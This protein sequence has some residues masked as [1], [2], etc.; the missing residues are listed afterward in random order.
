[1]AYKI[2][3]PQTQFLRMRRLSAKPRTI[4]RVFPFPSGDGQAIAEE[5]NYHWILKRTTPCMGAGCP[6]CKMA[7]ETGDKEMRARTKYK[8]ALCDTTDHP[9]FAY[10]YEVTTTV[11]KGIYGVLQ[12]VGVDDIESVIGNNG[13]DII[14]TFDRGQPPSSQYSVMPSMKK[15]TPLNAVVDMAAQAERPMSA[16]DALDAAARGDPPPPT[17]SGD[18]TNCEVTTTNGKARGLWNGKKGKKG[19]LII[20]IDGRLQLFAPDKVAVDA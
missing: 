4:V 10:V 11:Y 14:V 15:S 16:E 1:M 5:F 12:E 2:P 7:A 17:A 3:V 19:E 6:H 9:A 18:K 13:K 20:E 8:M